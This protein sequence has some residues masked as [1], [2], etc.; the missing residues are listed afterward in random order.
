MTCGPGGLE[1][2]SIEVSSLTRDYADDL[3]N[4]PLK[5]TPRYERFSMIKKA[6]S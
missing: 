5:F 6:L 4:S 3:S 2:W 1:C